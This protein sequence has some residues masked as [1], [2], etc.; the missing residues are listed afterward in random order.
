[1]KEND[2]DRFK[3]SL[4]P[5]VEPTKPDEVDLATVNNTMRRFGTAPV[6]PTYKRRARGVYLSDQ[7]HSG[8][9]AIAARENLYLSRGVMIGAPSVS[10]L[11]ECIGLGIYH[12]VPVEGAPNS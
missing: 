5:P 1:M 4:G 6:H 2:L 8:L 12:V 3:E 11:M 10:E 7:A 9:Q